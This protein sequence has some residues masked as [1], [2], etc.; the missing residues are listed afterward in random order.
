MIVHPDSGA[1][2]ILKPSDTMKKMVF[3]N[4]VEVSDEDLIEEMKKIEQMKKELMKIKNN[5]KSVEATTE[6]NEEM[7]TVMNSAENQAEQDIDYPDYVEDFEADYYDE[8]VIQLLRNPESLR[9][10]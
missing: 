7:T 3:P 6:L 10:R 4:S 2:E 5:M 8:S 1:I 9:N